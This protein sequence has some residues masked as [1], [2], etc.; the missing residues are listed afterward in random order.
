VAELHP[1][2]IHFPIALA[3]LWP[4]I[5]LLGLLLKKPDLSRLGLGLLGF[6]LLSSLV[7]T[8]T[9]QAAFD[10]ALAAKVAPE[11]LNTHA[12]DAN[13]LPWL[14]LLLLVARF[15]LAQRLGRVG[16]GAAI[17][18]GVLALLFVYQV[19]KSGGELVYRHGVGVQALPQ[20]SQKAN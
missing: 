12:D 8:A 9:G 15:L 6:A 10:Q 5:D 7:A 19:G 17:G 20:T 3:L 13:L 4:V 14:W 18:L 1:I 2:A 16:H 11:L